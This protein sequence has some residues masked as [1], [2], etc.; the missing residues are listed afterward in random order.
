MNTLVIPC[1][2]CKRK[3]KSFYSLKKHVILKHP[4]TDTDT[5]RPRFLDLPSTEILPVPRVLKGDLEAYKT[6][7][8]A[9]VERMN[10][11]Y[12]PQIPG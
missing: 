3:F 9:L 2:D 6:W 7:L 4:T 1:D 8:A 11:A 5:L 12:H 10:S